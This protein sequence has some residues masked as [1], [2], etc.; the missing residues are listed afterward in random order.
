MVAITAILIAVGAVA[1]AIW[2]GV[3]TVGSKA[4]DIARDLFKFLVDMF[5]TFLNV[6]PTAVKILFFFFFILTMANVVVGFFIQINYACHEGELREYNGI[7]GGFRGYYESIGEDLE[8]STTDYEAYILEK[9]AVSARFG[10]GEEYTDVLN[11]RCFGNTPRLSFFKI[12]FLNA[13]LWFVILIIGMLITIK[14][15]AQHV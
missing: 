4:L 9:T 14:I 13:K 6:A 12:D 11:V 3:K 15:K 5:R 2:E 8:N 1:S 10:D 7:I